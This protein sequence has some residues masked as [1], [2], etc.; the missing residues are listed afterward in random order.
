MKRF[1]IIALLVMASLLVSCKKTTVKTVEPGYVTSYI[2]TWPL[3]TGKHWTA[4]QIKSEYLS[5]LIISFARIDA[6][7]KYSLY[8][9]DAQVGIWDEVAKV[10]AR[11]PKLEVTLSVGGWGGEFSDTMADP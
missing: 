6:G 7:D 9:P 1:L 5:H 2:R 11:C 10:K 3:S 8:M 4:D